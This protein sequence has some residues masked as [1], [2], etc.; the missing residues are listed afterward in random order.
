MAEWVAAEGVARAGAPHL[1]TRRWNFPCTWTPII[2]LHWSN[3]NPPT[4]QGSSGRSSRSSRKFKEVHALNP[5][6]K[7]RPQKP[8]QSPGAD[9][10]LM[11][12]L[13]GQLALGMSTVALMGACVSKS[14]LTE[15]Y[16]EE[17]ACR[18]GEGIR[19]GNWGWGLEGWDLDLKDSGYQLVGMCVSKPVR[20]ER[21]AQGR[22]SGLARG[23]GG[24]GGVRGE[25]GGGG[26]I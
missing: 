3:G 1:M 4:L 16:R 15:M 11:T 6:P 13:R 14:D 9:P 19:G 23:R 24:G 5:H 10:A 17:L 21:D 2:T 18:A 12:W 25:G 22:R 8:S 7:L 26:C 20:H